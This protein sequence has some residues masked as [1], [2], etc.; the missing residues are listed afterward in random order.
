M[1]P[2]FEPARTLFERLSGGSGPVEVADLRQE[3]AAV[4]PRLADNATVAIPALRPP[5]PVPDVSFADL[6]SDD[7]PLAGL[8]GFE[9]VAA[10]GVG[11]LRGAIEAA[12]AAGKY[13]EAVTLA[14]TDA[15]AVAKDESLRQLVARARDHAESEPYVGRFLDQARAAIQAGQDDEVDRLLA[16]VR[17]STTAS[18]L[19]E[20]EQMRANYAGA[21]PLGNRRRGIEMEPEPRAP[22]RCRRSRRRRR[23]RELTFEDVDEATGPAARGGRPASAGRARAGRAR[24]GAPVLAARGI[25]RHGDAQRVGESDRRIAELLEEGQKPSTAASIKPLSTPGRGSSSSTSIMARPPAASSRRASSRQSPSAR[26]KRSSTRARRTSTPAGR[27][28]QGGAQ[29]GPR[30]AARAPR[31][32]RAAA[33][34]R[35]A[36]IRRAAPA[37]DGARG[38]AVAAPGAPAATARPAPGREARRRGSAPAV[39]RRPRRHRSGP[40]ST[41]AARCWCWLSPA[42]PSSGSIG[43]ASSPI[44]PG[45]RD[46]SSGGA[47]DPIARATKAP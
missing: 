30:A 2:A 8:G 11:D 40:S 10:A 9:A 29:Q 33:A 32:A 43:T 22:R 28:S 13:G 23:P 21:A 12:M 16:K 24:A 34:R 44:G 5:P 15:A 4:A 27:R 1:D 26:S 46:R 37:A 14:N 3:G 31:G 18:R 36:A 35:G 19:A 20:I 41:S 6:E 45:A 47:S 42:V 25:R 39:R 7:N 38:R 17:R